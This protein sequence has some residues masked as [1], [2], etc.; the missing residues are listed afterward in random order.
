MLALVHSLYISPVMLGHTTDV[1][2]RTFALGHFVDIS[3][4]ANS[5]GCNIHAVLKGGW[6]YVHAARMSV[7]Q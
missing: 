4:I 5:A 6:E 2:L 7:E 3:Y 1:A